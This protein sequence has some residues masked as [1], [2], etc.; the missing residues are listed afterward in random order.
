MRAY[1][2]PGS[3]AAMVPGSAGRGS[4]GVDPDRRRVTLAD[5]GSF[6]YDYMVSPRGC[7]RLYGVTGPP[8]HRLGMLIP[9]ATRWS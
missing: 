1:N 6:G 9:A 4:T 2:G 8:S 3:H 5:G 7:P